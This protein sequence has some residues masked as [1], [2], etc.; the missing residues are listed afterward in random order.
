[1]SAGNPVS[2]S[3]DGGTHRIAM[4]SGPR[5]LS[6]ALMRSWGSRRD[7]HVVDE[8]FYAYYLDRTGLPHPGRDDVLASQSNDWRAVV[9]TLTRQPLPDGK[10]V[11]FQKHMTHHMLPEVD[12]STVDGLS[13][14][15]LIRDPAEVLMSYAKVRGEPTLE[16]VGLPRQLELYER[17]GGPVVDARDLLRDPAAILSRLCAALD[18]AYDPAMLSWAPG[19][20]PTDGVWAE[21]WYA[22]VRASTGFD[23]PRSSTVDVPVALRPLL[24]RCRPYYDTMAQHRLTASG[25]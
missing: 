22:G 24:Q 12:L 14:A 9:E 16:D 15:F 13:H 10:T 21:H 17:F 1:M 25:G 8:P 3:T 19:P 11:L 23:R 7:C 6:T 5:N 4:W 18:I 2:G 20:R